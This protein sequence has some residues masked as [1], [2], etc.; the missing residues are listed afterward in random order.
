MNKQLKR[1]YIHVNINSQMMVVKN[2]KLNKKVEILKQIASENGYLT[3]T[4]YVTSRIAVVSFVEEQKIVLEYEVHEEDL[5]IGFARA[6][7]VIDG[8]AEDLILNLL[9]K[10]F[11]LFQSNLYIG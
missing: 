9:G 3:T 4:Y 10:P 11:D 2:L 6:A 5:F 1:K 7:R 8:F